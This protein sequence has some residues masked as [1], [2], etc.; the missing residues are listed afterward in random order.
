M[1]TPLKN[2]AHTMS[3]ELNYETLAAQLRKPT[4]NEGINIS[5]KMNESNAH[6]T[7]AAIRSLALTKGD[8]VIEMGPG[9]GRLSLPIFDLIGKEGL[10]IAI[11]YSNEMTAEITNNLTQAGFTNFQVINADFQSLNV[12]TLPA[13]ALFAVNVLYFIDNLELFSSKI[14][15]LLKPNARIVFGVRTKEIMNNLPF[16]RYKFN[17]RDENEYLGAFKNGGFQKIQITK[18]HTGVFNFNGVE[19]NN[20]FLIIEMS[21]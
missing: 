1:L 18:H 2:Q 14:R 9:N 8:V 3:Q 7:E 11:D 6:I 15:Q 19:F 20:E 12:H 13:N 5:L 16:T 21:S 17:I 4:G 10:Y